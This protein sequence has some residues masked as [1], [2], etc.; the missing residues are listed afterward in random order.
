MTEDDKPKDERPFHVRAAEYLQKT[1]KP[2][3]TAPKLLHEGKC[4]AYALL[5]NGTRPDVVARMFG[6]SR[7]TVSYIAGCRED[8]RV[9][10]T[11]ETVPGHFE[12]LGG[13]K[14]KHR[15]VNRKPRYQEVADEFETLGEDAFLER[16][17]SKGLVQRSNKAW[18]E[19]CAEFRKKKGYRD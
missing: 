15:N 8:N 4:E 10:T 18:S 5:Y 2:S 9:A 12:T 11:F 1:Y 17:L 6:I 13:P 19:I 7:S 16:Y 3:H 14:I